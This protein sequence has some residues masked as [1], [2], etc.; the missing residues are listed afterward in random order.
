VCVAI[1]GL[2]FDASSFFFSFVLGDEVL[3]RISCLNGFVLF[4]VPTHT[5]AR[6][7]HTHTY[8]YIHIYA[9]M[10]TLTLSLFQ[11][12]ITTHP[13]PPQKKIY[14]PCCSQDTAFKQTDAKNRIAQLI[15]SALHPELHK[16]QEMADIYTLGYVRTS[17]AKQEDEKADTHG[18]GSHSSYRQGPNLLVVDRLRAEMREAF[19]GKTPHRDLSH[20]LVPMCTGQFAQPDSEEG[21]EQLNMSIV[22]IVPEEDTAQGGL[23]LRTPHSKGLRKRLWMAEADFDP[24][25]VERQQRK[26]RA[27]NA[28]KRGGLLQLRE[29]RYDER[30]H[31]ERNRGSRRGCGRGRGGFGGRSGGQ[32][33][34]FGRGGRGSGRGGRGRV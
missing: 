32:G 23:E 4:G 7:P 21:K 20:A 24:R 2:L 1:V 28:A 5:L 22:V 33:R 31:S 10:H 19:S 34:G 30:G 18:G 15:L 8:I 16:W 26:N 25:W 14:L 6:S 12:H 29:E 3:F 27:R 11:S 17:K 9:H 13:P